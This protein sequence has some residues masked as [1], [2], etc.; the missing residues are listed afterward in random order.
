[1]RKHLNFNSWRTSVTNEDI[2]TAMAIVSEHEN[3]VAKASVPW[4]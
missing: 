1:M 4:M 3:T 2:G